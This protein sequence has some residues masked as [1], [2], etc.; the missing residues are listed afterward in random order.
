MAVRRLRRSRMPFG[1][2]KNRSNTMCLKRSRK[3]WSRMVK[4]GI[5]GLGA[6][7]PSK[8]L[9][10]FDLEKMVETSDEWIRSRTG[11]KERRISALHEK[12]SDLATK[13][14]IQALKD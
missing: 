13:A 11:I 4:V 10:N 14:A 9:T 5:L 1:L 8:R 3:R 2:P 6:Y 7:L 12:T